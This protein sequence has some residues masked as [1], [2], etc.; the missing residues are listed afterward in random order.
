MSKY[1]EEI[2]KLLTNDSFVAWI[3]GTASEKEVDQW[4]LWL[5]NDPA[6]KQL[7]EEARSLHQDINFKMI[8]RP[9]VEA[10]LFKLREE[11]D[12]FEESKEQEKEANVFQLNRK[13]SYYNV[14]AAIIFLLITVISTVTLLDKPNFIYSDSAEETT[15]EYITKS[16]QNGEQ[17]VLTLSDGSTITLNA[18]SSLRYPS[19]HSGED[20]EVWLEGEAYFDIVNKTGPDARL[21]SVNVSGGTVEVLGTKFNVNTY[22]QKATEVVLVEG[23]VDLKMRDTLNQTEDSY[24]M[25]PGEMSLISQISE[26]ISTRKVESD[27]YTA[28]THDKLVFDRTPLT[29]VAKRVKHIYGVHFDLNGYGLKETLVSGSLPSNNIEVFLKTLENM[30]DRPVLKKNGVIMVGEKRSD[31]N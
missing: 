30:L 24:E 10:E 23:R 3:E 4:K 25:S 19:R 1:E 29:K 8:E 26:N 9:E 6:R 17:K 13:K 20:L 14:A 18:N 16:T 5:E 12:R 11:V 7:A 31:Q 22:E 15:R 2:E 21:F 28:W 27:M